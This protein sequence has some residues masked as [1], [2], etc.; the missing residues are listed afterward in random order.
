MNTDAEGESI[1]VE[2]ETLVEP[3]K[4]GPL[5]IYGNVSV[6]KSQC[7]LMKKNNVTAFLQVW[8]FQQ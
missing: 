5:L 1:E 2:A 8:R 3:T 7:I 6:K 4:D